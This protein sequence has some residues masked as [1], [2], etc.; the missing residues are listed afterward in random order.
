MSLWI[1]SALIGLGAL[2]LLIGA[3]GLLR[4]PE[5]FS[6]THAASLTDSTG[7]SLILIGLAVLSGLSLITAKLLIMLAFLIFTSPTASHALARAALSDGLKP[8]QGSGKS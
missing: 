1:A 8:M 3:L 6:R 4:L 7:A 5:Y 2:V